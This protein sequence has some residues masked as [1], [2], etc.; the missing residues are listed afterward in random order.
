MKYV[1]SPGQQVFAQPRQVRKKAAVSKYL[2]D[3]GALTFF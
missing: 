2:C 3:P 1:S